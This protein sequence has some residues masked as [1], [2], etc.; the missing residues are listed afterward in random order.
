MNRQVF[1]IRY[2]V[3]ALTLITPTRPAIPKTIFRRAGFWYERSRHLRTDQPWIFRLRSRAP[4][5]IASIAPKWRRTLVWLVV[6]GPIAILDVVLAKSWFTTIS[7]LL[8]IAL[9]GAI[10]FAKRRR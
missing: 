7:T 4:D 2:T 9:I 8:A 6:V 3:L 1:W 5:V 10:F